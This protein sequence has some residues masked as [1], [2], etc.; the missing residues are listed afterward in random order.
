M[1][2]KALLQSDAFKQ[3]I[4]DI[5]K[6]LYSTF[7]NSQPSE[8]E[9]RHAAYCEL[10]ALERTQAKLQSYLDNQSVKARYKQ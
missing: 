7:E 5:K 6:D 2:A 9:V 3:A 4:D 1:D 10:K 8:V